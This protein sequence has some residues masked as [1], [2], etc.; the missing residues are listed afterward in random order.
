MYHPTQP[1]GAEGATINPATINPAALNSGM[2]RFD[3]FYSLLLLPLEIELPL[4][5]GLVLSGTGPYAPALRRDAIVMM[6]LGVISSDSVDCDD[7]NCDRNNH[8]NYNN[9]MHISLLEASK[10]P[11]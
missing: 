2:S 4:R 3:L 9:K 10:S 1:N 7:R 6:A 5:F 8:N 11:C